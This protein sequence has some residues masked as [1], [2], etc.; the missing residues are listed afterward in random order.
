MIVGVDPNSNEASRFGEFTWRH[1]EWNK[2]Y[3]GSERGLN[4][5]SLL[6]K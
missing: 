3:A 2:I 1:G 4:A 5:A 6:T